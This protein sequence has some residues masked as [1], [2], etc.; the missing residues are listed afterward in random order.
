VATARLT[1]VPASHPVLAVQL[2]LEH[3]GIPYVRRDLP[4][5]L[6]KLVLPLLGYRERTVPVLRI[7]GRRVQGSTGIAR[8]LDELQPQPPLF[9][10]DAASR[11]RVEDLERWID[12]DF[13]STV[14]ALAQWAAKRDTGA[15]APIALASDIPLPAAVMRTVLPVMGP[16][17]LSTVRVTREQAHAALRR[18]PDELDRLDAAIAD[19]II[20]GETPNAADYQ[21]AT[22][23]RLA[24]L[25]AALSPLLANRPVTA[26]A[27]RLAPHYPGRFAGGLGLE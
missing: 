21:A 15:L 3:K 23:V 25:V 9:P 20:D 16:A 8:V 26:L 12:T 2:M 24:T 14:R 6:Q 7:E 18:L 5:Q 13:Q 17:I 27:H 10:A 1:G 19:G 11:R 4:S 22:S